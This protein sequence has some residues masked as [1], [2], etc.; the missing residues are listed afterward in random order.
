VRRNY[1]IW[2]HWDRTEQ[3]T[4]EEQASECATNTEEREGATIQCRTYQFQ[5]ASTLS[6]F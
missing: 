3:E 4:L 1:Y 2:H 5:R 6:R